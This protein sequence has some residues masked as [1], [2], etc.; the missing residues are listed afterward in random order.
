MNISSGCLVEDFDLFSFYCRRCH[1]DFLSLLLIK[2]HLILLFSDRRMLFLS[3]ERSTISC[4]TVWSYRISFLLLLVD[5]KGREGERKK[6]KE[7][8]RKNPCFRCDVTKEIKMFS[9][10]NLIVWC[11]W[12]I[13]IICREM[14][15]KEEKKDIRE[16]F[17][18]IKSKRIISGKIC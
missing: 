14:T 18:G 12:E 4:W 1:V 13:G 9:C 5:S 15:T 3:L 11:A 8:K 10:N 16:K 6:K 2:V 17:N 7:R